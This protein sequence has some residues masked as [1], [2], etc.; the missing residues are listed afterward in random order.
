MEARRLALFAA[1]LS[2]CAATGAAGPRGG[3][4]AELSERETSADHLLVVHY[5]RDFLKFFVGDNIHLAGPKGAARL[6]DMFFHAEGRPISE[7]LNELI[8]K[9]LVCSDSP[10]DTVTEKIQRDASCFGGLPGLERSCLRTSTTDP[11]K[12]L[13]VW[14]CVFVKNHH[15]FAFGYSVPTIVRAEVEPLLRRVLAAAEAN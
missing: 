7:D 3:E 4:S 1:A 13:F 8:R 15:H 2:A 6:S 12:Q 5:P 14:E 9:D 11:T 10:P